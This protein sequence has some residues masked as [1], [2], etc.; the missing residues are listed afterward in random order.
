M[1]RSLGGVFFQE[2][3]EFDPAD[4]LKTNWVMTQRFEGFLYPRRYSMIESSAM[5][6]E[7]FQLAMDHQSN[8]D[9]C[10]GLQDQLDGH[11]NIQVDLRVIFELLSNPLC[12]TGQDWLDL[13]GASNVFYL[14]R[15]DFYDVIAAVRLP[16]GDQRFWSL[17]VHDISATWGRNT[18]IIANKL[19]R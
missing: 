14:G 10:Q 9:I 7:F 2:Q 11:V 5:S 13:T 19:K 8:E 12:R 6:L 16:T 18:R 4:F 17:D 1:L 15:P 3:K